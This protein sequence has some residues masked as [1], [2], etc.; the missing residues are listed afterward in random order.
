V[1]EVFE[2]VVQ[3]THARHACHLSSIGFLL[4]TRGYRPFLSRFDR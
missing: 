4:A 3:R 1:D 2:A